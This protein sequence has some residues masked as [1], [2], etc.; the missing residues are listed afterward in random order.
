[1]TRW[2]TRGAAMAFLFASLAEDVTARAQVPGQ[3]PVAAEAAFAEARSLMAQGRAAEACP[4][5]EASYALDPAVGTLLNLGDCF[6]RIGR[7]AS[8]WVRFRDA[9]A[10]AVNQNQREREA[11]A[12]A[13]AAA[14]EPRLCRLVIKGPER[15]DLAVMRDQVAVARPAL[16]IP[17]PVD[18]GPHTIEATA[19]GAAPFAIKVEVRPPGGGASCPPTVV[20]IPELPAT[21]DAQ[22]AAAAPAPAVKPIELGPAPGT[23]APTAA[24]ARW[25]TAHTLGVVSVATGLVGVVVGAAFALDASSTQGKADAKCTSAG[26]TPEGKTLLADA[27]SSADIATVGFVAGTVLLATGVV[28]WLASPSLRAA[29]AP[30]PSATRDLRAGFRF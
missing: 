4:K 22:R 1:M 9:A 6:E 24:T 5:L 30:P 29:G 27:G 13:R 3:D 14:L 16:G 7:T 17:V 12:R 2:H 28:L 8:A 23:A 15:S 19:P 11:V 10:M 25:G 21:G 26:C 20:V 18:P